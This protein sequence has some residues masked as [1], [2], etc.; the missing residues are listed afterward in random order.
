MLKPQRIWQFTCPRYYVICNGERIKTVI[1]M[2]P[3]RNLRLKTF[4][5]VA[6]KSGNDT[7]IRGRIGGKRNIDYITVAAISI[8][9]VQ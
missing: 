2:F 1:F 6:L 8:P 7:T 9:N 3:Y 4:E 5:V